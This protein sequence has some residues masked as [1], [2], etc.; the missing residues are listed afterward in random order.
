MKGHTPV[1]DHPWRKMVSNHCDDQGAVVRKKVHILS[2]SKVPKF[3]ASDEKLASYVENSIRKRR[4]RQIRT[5][6]TGA[7]LSDLAR[8][9][10]AL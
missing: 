9:S 5:G 7:H 4:R 2:E 8:R 1:A 10:N 6:E 3:D